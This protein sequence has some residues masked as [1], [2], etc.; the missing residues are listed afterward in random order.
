M[1]N[2]ITLREFTALPEQEQLNIIFTIGNFI[3]TNIDDRNNKNILYSVDRFFVEYHYNP[4]DSEI[5]KIY[6][7]E[8][9]EFLDKYSNDF[10]GIL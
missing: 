5:K 4:E 2:R 10:Q 8:S 9:G 1:P 6:P 3:E 7:F